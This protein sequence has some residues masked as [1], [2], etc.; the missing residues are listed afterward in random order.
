MTGRISARIDASSVAE[1]IQG[2]EFE[3]LA[4]MGLLAV[5]MTADCASP[6]TPL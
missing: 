4:M 5:V 6:L 2:V 3:L 1:V